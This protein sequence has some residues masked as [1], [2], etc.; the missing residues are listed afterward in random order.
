MD[1]FV[2][3]NYCLYSL[4]L[5]VSLLSFP[6]LSKCSKV[7]KRDPFVEES[8]IRSTSNSDSLNKAVPL[9][10]LVQAVVSN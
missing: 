1:S 8:A 5:V 9:V 7:E 3:T 6:L 4:A 2:V 10:I